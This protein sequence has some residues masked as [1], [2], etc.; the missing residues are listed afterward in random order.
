MNRIAEMSPRFKARIA[1]LLYL[2]I[3]ITAPSGAASATPVGGIR[4]GEE[5]LTLWLIVMG[6]NNMRWSEQDKRGAKS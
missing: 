1:G 6:V 5:F 3:F 4:V 2:L